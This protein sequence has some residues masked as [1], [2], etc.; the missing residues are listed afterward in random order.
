M[1][2][3]TVIQL[4]MQYMLVG[5]IGS[6][7][8]IGLFL[9]GYFL[10]Y[11][12]LMKGSK[13]LK[14]SKIALCSIFLI[15]ITVV[16]GATIGSRVSNYSSVNLHLFSSYKDAYNNFSLGEWRNIILNILMFV[17]IGFLLPLL[18]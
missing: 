4:V 8:V 15:Y 13:K 7:F 2:I 18:F 17:P 16:L 14:L 10:V 11:K 1:R 6:I 9:I 12:K 3:S 5:I